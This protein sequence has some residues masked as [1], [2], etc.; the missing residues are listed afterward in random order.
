M[1]GEYLIHFDI[2]SS[3]MKLL[4]RDGDSLVGMFIS[5]MNC[6]TAHCTR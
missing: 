5:C 1:L 6:I 2:A 3:V 4:V